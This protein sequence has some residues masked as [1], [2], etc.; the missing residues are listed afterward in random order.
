MTPDDDIDS[1]W[2][3]IRP[4]RLPPEEPK[5]QGPPENPSLPPHPFT[6]IHILLS[7]AGHHGTICRQAFTSLEGDL[8]FRCA[9]GIIFRI[10]LVSAR[11]SSRGFVKYMMTAGDR[12]TTARRLTL[13]PHQFLREIG[14]IG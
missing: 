3:E 2:M 13:E 9:C 1:M 12:A 5:V 8:G 7:A 14:E 6:T 4:V 10:G 11:R